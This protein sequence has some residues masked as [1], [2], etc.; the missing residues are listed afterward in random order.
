MRITYRP[1][2]GPLAVAVVTTLA[3]LLAL[4]APALGTAT[5]AAPA[6]V[7]MT[8]VAHDL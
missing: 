2:G 5:I 3:A 4:A 1:R 8:M 6:S 7:R